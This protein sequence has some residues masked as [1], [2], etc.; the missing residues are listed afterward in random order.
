MSGGR[1]P[2]RLAG[3]V[4]EDVDP[5]YRSRVTVRSG[6]GPDKL[7]RLPGEV[8]EIRMG[9]HGVIAERLGAPA[10]LQPHATTLDYVVAAA[11]ACLSGTF[12]RALAVRGIASD[13]TVYRS[14]AIGDVHD[15]DGVLVLERIE[16]HHTLSLSPE[17][18]PVAE[19]VHAVYERGCAVSR[20]IGGAV[21][22]ESV[23]ITE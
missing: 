9:A 14:E 17:E 2:D 3:P 22:I 15:R 12:A 16:I 10:D 20:S 5:V 11:A 23:L 1:R 19:R 8:E 21:E 13:P 6:G 7:V 18:L 4:A